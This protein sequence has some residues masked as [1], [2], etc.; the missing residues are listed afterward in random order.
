MRRL[1]VLVFLF[2]APLLAQE[3][4]PA[5]GPWSGNA[6]VGLS[7]TEGNSDT[8][9]LNL[10]LA[11]M[12]DPKTR[13]V[14][15][16]DALYMRGDADGETTIDRANAGVRD[17]YKFSDRTYGYG[18]VRWLRDELKEIESLIT[19]MVGAGRDLVKTDAY[20][21]SVDGGVGAIFEKN[22][23]FDQRTD[24]AFQAREVF[25]WT[26]SPTA[27]FSETLSGLWKFDDVGDALYHFDAA[28]ATTITPRSELKVSLASDYK[29]KPSNPALEK[30]D[31]S[32]IA[33]LV[34]KFP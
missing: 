25:T 3:P 30:N 33:A 17:E 29:A 19:P 12:F 22:T 16:F 31:V 10:A 26:I 24:G 28:I 20:K 8:T 2:T 11:T 6:A 14:V 5:A 4:A 15:K 9:N 27:N 18:E 32:L 13:N 7:L 23:G 34:M 21:L 1:N